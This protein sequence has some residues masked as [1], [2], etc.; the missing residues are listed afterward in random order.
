MVLEKGS[1]SILGIRRSLKG[2]EARA[3]APQETE[4][5]RDRVEVVIPVR[6]RTFSR[7]STPSLMLLPLLLIG[8]SSLPPPP[9]PLSFFPPASLSPRSCP[10]S[11]HRPQSSRRP[12]L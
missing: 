10:Q 4:K 12:P 1:Q 2:S 9:S 5:A 3:K 6:H 7:R 11:S 8:R